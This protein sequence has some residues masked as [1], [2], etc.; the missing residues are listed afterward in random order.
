[1]RQLTASS[2]GVD[3]VYVVRG[4]PADVDNKACSDRPGSRQSSHQ[5]PWAATRHT[6]AYPAALCICSKFPAL[7]FR[8][9]V[10]EH[11]VQI[12]RCNDQE[13]NTCEW[14]TY[15]PLRGV[16]A[17]KSADLICPARSPGYS[18]RTRPTACPTAASHS[19][20][21]ESQAARTAVRQAPNATAQQRPAA[22]AVA[23]LTCP[24]S[25]LLSARNRLNDTQPLLICQVAKS[26]RLWR[27]NTTHED[28]FKAGA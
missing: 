11:P 24:R 2:R 21:N 25:V 15:P 5:A 28:A 13:D 26:A 12:G 6:S 22:I 14:S 16:C 4:V 18:Q 20:A 10:R 8:S 23:I 7:S 17:N 3:S 1:M 27:V 9:S 19:P